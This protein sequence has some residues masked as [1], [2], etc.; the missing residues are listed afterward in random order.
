[1][2]V[3]YIPNIINN[4]YLFN[5]RYF[6]LNR[7]LSLTHSATRPPAINTAT[8]GGHPTI[9][10]DVEEVKVVIAHSERATLRVDACT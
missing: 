4:L 7:R 3:S 6:A 5:N 2:K 1:M 9:L 10:V 8:F